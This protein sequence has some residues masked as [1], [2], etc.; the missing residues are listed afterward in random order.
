MFRGEC[1]ATTA[2]VAFISM[3]LLRELVSSEDGF[4]YRHGAPNGAVPPSQPSVSSENSEE[5]SFWF[6][7]TLSWLQASD[8]A[9]QP[10]PAFLVPT[11]ETC[12]RRDSWACTSNLARNVRVFDDRLPGVSGRSM[13]LVSNP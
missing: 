12:L 4:C 6:G 7:A 9:I 8:F 13:L 10:F 11:V 5:A 1:V 2:F 3:P